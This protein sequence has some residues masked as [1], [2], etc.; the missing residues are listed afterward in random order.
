MAT[1]WD[2]EESSPYDIVWDTEESSPYLGD[3]SNITKDQWAQ[4]THVRVAY[5]DDTFEWVAFKGLDA[6]GYKIN[7]APSSRGATT[8]CPEDVWGLR[9]K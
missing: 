7:V 5:S 1:V 8:V 2:T 6:Q 9:F 4:V 3:L